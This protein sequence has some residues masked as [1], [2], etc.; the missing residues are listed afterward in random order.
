M[1]FGRIKNAGNVDF[2]LPPDHPATARV[3]A[4]GDGGALRAYVGCPIWQDDAMARKLCPPRTPKTKRLACYGK[5][6]NALELN[7]TGYG[8]ARERVEKWSADVPDGFRFC[9]KVPME[10]THGS[11]LDWV[12]DS[13]ARYCGDAEAFGKR[14]GMLFLQFPEQFGPDRFA[15]LERLLA[16]RKAGVPLAVEV[17]HAAWF[18]EGEWRDRLFDMLEEQGVTG[19]LSDT[20]GRRDALHQ[21]LTTSTAFIRFN[22]QD[23]ERD[24]RRLEEWAGRIRKWKD[25]GLRELYFFPHMDPKDMTVELSA[26]FI[27]SLNALAGLKLKEP[28]LIEE[29]EEPSLGL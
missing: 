28:R 15:E 23:M 21:R 16:T 8:L 24:P 11:N 12:K 7:S 3:L 17:R 2:T 20:A 6:F 27:K 4:K 18:R 22:G 10:V 13:F 29:I 1:D 26:Y 25:R 5:Q 19:I 9:P 14:L